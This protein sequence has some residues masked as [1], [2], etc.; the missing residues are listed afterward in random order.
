MEK[1]VDR[2]TRTIALV[3]VAR[4]LRDRQGSIVVLGPF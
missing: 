2:M 3:A 1:A 4:R